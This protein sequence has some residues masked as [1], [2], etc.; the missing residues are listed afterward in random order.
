MLIY[1]VTLARAV[2]KIAIRSWHSETIVIGLKF[3]LSLRNRHGEET[4]FVTGSN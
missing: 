2:I 4:K 1:I 3:C